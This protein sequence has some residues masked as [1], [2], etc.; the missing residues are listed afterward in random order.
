MVAGGDNN[1]AVAMGPYTKPVFCGARLQFWEQC[2]EIVFS[3][4]ADTSPQVFGPRDDPTVTR[5]LPI[6]ISSGS[7]VRSCL[8]IPLPPRTRHL[9]FYHPS[10]PHM[11][12]SIYLTKTFSAPPH[13]H[14]LRF[15]RVWQFPASYHTPHVSNEIIS[16]WKTV[17]A[18]CTANLFSAGR[19]DRASFYDIWQGVTA[20]FSVCVRK[21]YSGSVRGIGTCSVLL[22]NGD[23]T[24]VR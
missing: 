8:A 21:G 15:V 7:F 17:D 12:L 23:K 16:V 19:T 10:R 1:V 3:M 22:S 5:G 24:S 18:K 11:S 9:F 6:R 4:P 14:Q 2:R 20:M 13:P